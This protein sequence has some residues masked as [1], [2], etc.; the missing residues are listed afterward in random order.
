MRRSGDNGARLEL[1]RMRARAKQEPRVAG[2]AGFSLVELLIGS[3][4]ALLVIGAAAS[5][6][7]SGI[8]A[9]PR[10][11]DRAHAIQDARVMAERITRELRMGSNAT[12][13]TPSQLTILTYVPTASCGGSGSGPATRC[14][15]FYS[16]A[17]DGTCT[18]T[19]CGP[20]TLV[21]PVGCGSPVR[22]VEGL[23]SNQV[24]AFTPRIPGQAMVSVKVAFPATE[25]D[26]AITI[27]DGA[28]LRN[29]PL[30]GP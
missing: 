6:F 21:P 24:F 7:T 12:S 26:D 11:A 13:P 5:V 27:E 17:T 28:A 8:G 25:N 20:N 10:I 23:A 19:E 30:G 22:I 3:V 14:R 15:V 2:E 4:L 18:R 9:E 16:C 1:L 29:P